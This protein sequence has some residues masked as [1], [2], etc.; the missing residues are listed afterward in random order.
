M[1]SEFSPTHRR[2]GPG[3][4]EVAYILR[5]VLRN[6]GKVARVANNDLEGQNVSI[7]KM[8]TIERIDGSLQCQKLSTAQERKSLSMLGQRE[9]SSDVGCDEPVVDDEI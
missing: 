6:G 4:I 9:K 7:S 2:R 3:A 5:L 1:M 8:V